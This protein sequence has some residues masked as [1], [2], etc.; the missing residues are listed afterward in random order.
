[1]PGE[2]C[3]KRSK[4]R[5]YLTV[6]KASKT[7]LTQNIAEQKRG[8]GLARQQFG[9]LDEKIGADPIDQPRLWMEPAEQQRGPESG[10]DGDD[11]VK[12][13]EKGVGKAPARTWSDKNETARGRLPSADVEARRGAR[14][15]G[16]G[17]TAVPTA[18]W[19]HVGAEPRADGSASIFS[20]IQPRTCGESGASAATTGDPG[21]EAGS[22]VAAGGEIG[23]AKKKCR[24]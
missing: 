18:C 10:I 3:G 20:S 9:R 5:P 6:I 2:Q 16:A 4:P 22:M 15:A 1:M 24:E 7:Q 12:A 19:Q 21:M 11:A 23:K 13:V 17:R 8:V 14:R